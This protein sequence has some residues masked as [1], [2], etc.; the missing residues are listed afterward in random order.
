LARQID[1]LRTLA[2]AL[3]MGATILGFLDVLTTALAWAEESIALSRQH[4]YAYEL[5]LISGSYL[6]LAAVANQPVP[7]GAHEEHLRAARATGNPWVIAMAAWNIARVATMHGNLAEAY[8]GFEEA[9]TLFQLIRDRPFYTSSRSETGHVFRIQGRYPEALTIYHE[10][11]RLWQELGQ[12]SAAAH[13][14]E[15]FA[16]I[17][18]ASGQNERAA[19][20]FGAAE[21]LRESI[22]SNMTPSERREYDR[23]VLQLHAQTDAAALQATWAAGR[24]LSMEQAIQ[25]ALAAGG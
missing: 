7:P 16:F 23:A 21:A 4:G 19:R 13:E 22:G 1:A 24:A 18:G 20:L 9:A 25:L 6:Y 12:Q 8:A 17:A 5:G 2:F 14:L 11:I 10:T 15:C 3:G